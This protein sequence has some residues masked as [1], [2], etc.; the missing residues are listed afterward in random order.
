[1]PEGKDV[2]DIVMAEGPEGL[3]ERIGL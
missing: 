3:R 2:N 1:M